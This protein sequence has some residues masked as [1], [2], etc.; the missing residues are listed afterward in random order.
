MLIH[1]YCLRVTPVITQKN[2]CEV[3]DEDDED[4]EDEDDDDG[5][6]GESRSKQKV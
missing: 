4:E 6:D 5:G 2:V 1:L 3:N